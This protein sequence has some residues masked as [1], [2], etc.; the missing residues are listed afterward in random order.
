MTARHSH[1]TA[2]TSS[3]IPFIHIYSHT[4]P[5]NHTRHNTNTMHHFIILYH[6]HSSK[7]LMTT[8]IRRDIANHKHHSRILHSHATH[9]PRS[10]RAGQNH[11]QVKAS[12]YARKIRNE[13]PLDGQYTLARPICLRKFIYFDYIASSPLSTWQPRDGSITLISRA[14]SHVQVS[15]SVVLN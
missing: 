13:Q 15:S 1:S 14:S 8:A 5:R 2:Q 9:T 6:S 4:A 3:V 11:Y 7:R 10:A 12:I